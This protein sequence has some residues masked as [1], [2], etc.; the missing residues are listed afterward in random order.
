M[1]GGIIGALSINIQPS[2]HTK[3]RGLS[4][5]L[6]AYNAGRICS[7]TLAGALAG[8]LGE[9]VFSLVDEQ[10]A[11][12]FTRLLSGLFLLALGFY[13]AGWTRSL[14]FLEQAGAHLWRFIK[15]LSNRFI[16]VRSIS[17][18]FG[19][20]LVWGWLPCGLVYSALVWALSAGNP[21][22]GALIMAIF[23]LATVPALF[24]TGMSAVKFAKFTKNMWARRA[25]GACVI[26]LAL[27]HLSAH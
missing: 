8:A 7:Y 20:G 23:G 4:T 10:A 26:A 5:Y 17:Q 13:L 2:Q 25:I 16:P 21:I 3:K 11:L 12:N 27:A 6:L 15:P 18:A 22:E 1:C 14:T 9:T 24:L 19:T